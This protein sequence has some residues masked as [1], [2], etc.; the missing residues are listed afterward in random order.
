MVAVAK[1]TLRASPFFVLLLWQLN[2]HFHLF[3]SSSAPWFY[4]SFAFLTI[5]S[6][7]WLICELEKKDREK[8][9]K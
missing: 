1:Q 7:I 2:K 3:P 6:F 9:K 4:F 5:A 8:A